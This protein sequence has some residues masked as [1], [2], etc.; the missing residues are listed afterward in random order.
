[1]LWPLFLVLVF[2]AL[3]AAAAYGIEWISAN[4]EGIQIVF[5]GYEVVLGPLQ[6]VFA[7]LALFVAVWIVLRV[8]SLFVGILA[9]L[10]ARETAFSRFFNRRR[11]R[12][13]NR[14]LGDGFL[15]LASGDSK[16]A[17]RKASKAEALLSRP[18]LGKLLAAQA[19]EQM[20]DKR[21]AMETYKA[22]L[23][24]DQTR[25]L[26]IRGLMK[27]KQGEGDEATA[28]ELAKKA[29]ELKPADGETAEQL[30]LMQTHDADWSGARRALALEQRHRPA[31]K[32]LAKRRDGL[33]A[34]SQARDLRASGELEEAQRAAMDAA[35]QLPNFA[36]A[37]VEGARAHAEV[38]NT[39]KAITLI[40]TAWA[41]EPH[42][43]LAAAFAAL[44]PDESPADRVKRFGDLVRKD[45]NHPEARMLM[46]EVNVA[47]E[48]FPAARRA[49]GDLVDS[50]PTARAMTLMAAIERGEGSDDTTVKAWLARAVTA[51]RGPQWVCEVEGAVYAQ[52]QPVCDVCGSFD[53]LTWKPAPASD[54][55]P[56][57]AVGMLPLIVGALEKKPEVDEAAQETAP[58]PVD[59][60]A[61]E[62]AAKG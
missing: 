55:M 61:Q 22:L 10:F 43:D 7:A 46:A 2:V 54:V 13:G 12:R 47:A 3:V 34:L 6:T 16:L 15:A 37:V 33:L 1:M 38:G 21:M 20:G 9:F 23:S 36:P 18:E 28:R 19:A 58:P 62:T 51:P 5:A 56:D 52:W 11:E 31:P 48:D 53:T 4:G 57:T 32:A 59:S 50:D 44:K 42:P 30:F 35:K 8:L 41:H 49:L 26:A 39:Q 24:D 29:L 25:F 17:L 27:H 14:I 60:T 40:K 45:P